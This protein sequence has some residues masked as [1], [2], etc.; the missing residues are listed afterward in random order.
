MGRVNLL[1]RTKLVSAVV[2]LVIIGTGVIG[3][4]TSYDATSKTT[5]STQSSQATDIKYEG[6]EGQNALDLLKKY[7]SVQ[8]AHYTLGDLVISINGIE[9]NGPKYWSFY[10]NSKLSDVG[11][12]SY[13]THIGDTI[14]WKLQ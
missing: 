6:V 9:G 4:L 3:A 12:D 1:S 13:I 5:I 2:P 8:T 7:A 14:E 11:A 10:V